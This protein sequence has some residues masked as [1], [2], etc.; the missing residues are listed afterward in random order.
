MLHVLSQEFH[1]FVS[2]PEKAWF[3]IW[4]RTNL[5]KQGIEVVFSIQPL[6]EFGPYLKEKEDKIAAYKKTINPSADFQPEVHR[7]AY[8]LSREVPAIKVSKR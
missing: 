1:P 2:I 4:T 6:P 8:Q 3:H 7:P 5:D